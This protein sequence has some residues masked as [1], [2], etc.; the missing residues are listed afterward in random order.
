MQDLTNTRYEIKMVCRTEAYPEIRLY[1][2]LDPS[3]I[4][5][6]YPKRRVQSVYLDTPEADALAENLAGISHREKFRYRWYGPDARGVRG[7]LECKVRENMLGW[8]RTFDID[9]PM[10]IEGADRVTF[11]KTLWEAI[12]PEWRARLA[13]KIEPVQWIA[14]DR[15]Y[16]RTADGKVRITVDQ[17]LRAWDQRGLGTL[18]SR[19]A[20][21]LPDMMVVEVKCAARDYEA[22]EAVVNRLPLFVDKCSKF[23]T[24]SMLGG[25][26]QVSVVPI[27]GPGR[28]I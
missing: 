9:E 11:L 23:V 5:T 27:T 24:A 10:D 17:G 8:K 14:Y 1:L 20:T 25:G 26:P 4:R 15:E 16:F 22:A 6:L 12:D 28:V 13:E 21:P 18:S 7:R 3:G 19:L 2:D